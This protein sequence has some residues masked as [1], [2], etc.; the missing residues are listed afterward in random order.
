LLA[1][2]LRNCKITRKSHYCLLHIVDL[3]AADFRPASMS[4]TCSHMTL[5]YWVLNFPLSA[6]LAVLPCDV[7]AGQQARLGLLFAADSEAGSAR[8]WYWRV[9]ASNA[10]AGQLQRLDGPY[11]LQVTVILC[12]RPAL[13]ASMVCRGITD[14]GIQHHALLWYCWSVCDSPALQVDDVLA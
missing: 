7:L 14:G 11:K 3:V 9:C 2:L 4:A 13:S 8:C 5:A 10:A 1:Q 6:V 12:S